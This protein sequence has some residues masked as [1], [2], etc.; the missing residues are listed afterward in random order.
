MPE[1]QRSDEEHKK[2]RVLLFDVL[3]ST[4]LI[5]QYLTTKMFRN[6]PG[7]CIAAQ[8]PFQASRHPI[9]ELGHLFILFRVPQRSA[10]TKNTG[11][12]DRFSHF[13]HHVGVKHGAF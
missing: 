2:G 1:W 8:A 3:S 10:S 9:L 4:S 5:R 6:I 13:S 7:K 12:F 11:V